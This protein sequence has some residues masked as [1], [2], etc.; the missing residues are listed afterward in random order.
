MKKSTINPTITKKFITFLVILFIIPVPLLSQPVNGEI[1]ADTG[2]IT[3]LKVWGSVEERGFAYGF[4]LGDKII[5]VYEGFTLPIIGDDLQLIKSLILEGETFYI[6]S[7]FWNQAEAII[8]GITA[9]GN[10]TAGYTAIDVIIGNLYYD[11]K[12]WISKKSA[13]GLNCSSF[14]NW[15]EATAG[16]DLDGNSVIAKFGDLAPNAALIDNFII[17]INI[18]EDENKIAWAHIGCAGEMASGINFNSNGYSIC[19]NELNGDH[20]WIPDTTAGYEPVIFTCTRAMETNDY[21]QDGETDMLD[22]KDIIQ[23]NQ[24]GYCSGHIFSV[25]GPSTAVYDSMIAVIAEVAP[26]DPYITFRTNT[27]SDSIPGD[28]L[29]AANRAISRNDAH[30]YCWRY[31]NMVNHIGDGTNIGSQENWDLMKEYSNSG[32]WSMIFAQFIP[33]WD[34]LKVSVYQENTPAYQIEP[35]TFDVSEFW[36]YPG[37]EINEIDYSC[38]PINVYPNPANTKLNIVV[39]DSEIENVTIYSITCHQVLTFQPTNE[40]IDIST[41]PPGMYIVEVTVEGSKVRRKVLVE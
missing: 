12:Y 33:E 9:A 39:E 27:Y 30:D 37:L 10:N 25:L 17:R 38:H 19:I 6:D 24:L 32:S 29:Y 35:I 5:D 2:N 23:S 22:F 40:T 14:M 13:F 26:E 36:G 8:E 20:T 28:N 41:L 7:S 11:L 15:N 16:T 3:V 34:Q 31:L 1:I 21:N 18:P 4:L